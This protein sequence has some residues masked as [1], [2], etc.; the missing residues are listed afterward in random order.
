MQSINPPP[1]H[2]Q[3]TP[4]PPP[5]VSRTPSTASIQLLIALLVPHPEKT[6]MLVALSA[7]SYPTNV[8]PLMSLLKTDEERLAHA[9]TYLI[10]ACIV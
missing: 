2:Q 9:A 5:S 10:E 7:V 1:H 6:N 8:T 4:A 3:L